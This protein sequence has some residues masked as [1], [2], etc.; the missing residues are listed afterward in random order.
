MTVPDLG[1]QLNR[2]VNSAR[3]IL[4]RQSELAQLT[5][6]AFDI[7]YQKV[8]AADGD[9]IELAYPVGW[10][11]E[12]KPIMSTRKY[13]KQQLMTEYQ[14]LAVKQLAINGV[15]HL[16]TVIE[17][18]NE[19]LLRAV[20]AKYPKKL[21][22]DRKI[23]IGSVLECG[24]IEAIHTHAIDTLLNELAYKSPADFAEAIRKQMGINL[25]ECTAFHRYIELKA[26]RDIYIHNRGI[27][28]RTYIQKAGQ[29]ARV[30]EGMFLPVDAQ[31]FLESFEQCVQ[32][33]EWWEE[34][35]HGKW[36]SSEFET[37]KNVPEAPVQDGVAS[38]TDPI[39]LELRALAAKVAG[40]AELTGK[41]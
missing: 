4:F 39:S 26:T 34:Q 13:S 28:S 21:G 32:L 12:R 16:V 31:Y 35:F 40:P 17:A 24:S 9:T 22:A 41:S 15:L 6:G 38:P 30:R 23:S 2:I 8:H 11:A 37:R 20:I 14:F 27:A 33:T 18:M 29:H 19:D 10:T 1:N 36:H 3:S 25:M 5:Y 7:A